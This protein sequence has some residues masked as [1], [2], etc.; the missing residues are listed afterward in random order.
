MKI[1]AGKKSLRLSADALAY[2]IRECGFWPFAELVVVGGFLGNDEASAVVAGVEPFRGGRSDSAGAVEAHAGAHFDERS[3]LRQFCRFLV[4]DPDE[5][6]PLVV[7]EDADRTDGNFIAGFG[8][9]DG[10]PIS[11]GQDDQA[12]D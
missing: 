1:L 12:D 2:H 4:F 5:G 6:E 11:G 9:A 10:M 8:L 3:A 7:L